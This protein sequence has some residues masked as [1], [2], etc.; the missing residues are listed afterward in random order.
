MKAWHP[1]GGATGV[2]A[3]LHLDLQFNPSIGKIRQPIMLLASQGD[4]FIS[5]RDRSGKALQSAT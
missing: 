2:R 1:T 4:G 3:R 5:W